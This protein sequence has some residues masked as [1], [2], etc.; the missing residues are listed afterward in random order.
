MHHRLPRPEECVQPEDDDEVEVVFDSSLNV[1]ASTFLQQARQE[2]P[3][4]T[5]RAVESSVMRQCPEE[6]E[7]K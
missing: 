4:E 2:V 3:A 6:E 5:L 1:V 7:R